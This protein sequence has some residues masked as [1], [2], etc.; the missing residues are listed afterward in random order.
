MNSLAKNTAFYFITSLAA[1]GMIFLLWIIL[2]W[3][4][5]P[6][7]IGVY[8]LA[9][10]VVELFGIV[11][12]FGL[13]PALARFYYADNN[14]ESN[15]VRVFANSFLIFLISSLLSLLLFIA[16]IN[17]ISF[18]IP[19]IAEV[20]KNNIVLLAGLI[21]ANSAVELILSNYTALKKAVVFSK[22]H[23]AR[24]ILFFVLSLAFISFEKSIVSIFLAFFVSS[25]AVI[26]YFFL[27][28]KKL[29]SFKTIDKN[30]I[31]QIASYGFPLMLYGFL[32][33][34]VLYFSRIILSWHVDLHSL[35]IYSF[36]LTIVL[37]IN[38]LWNTF[39]RAWTPEIFHSISKDKDKA[40]EQT[41]FMVFFSSF[42]YL[43]AIFF[44]MAAGELFLFKMIFKD[45]YFLNRMILYI[46]LIGPV[47]TGIYISIYPLC[48]YRKKSSKILAVSTFVSVLNILLVVL[49]VS[50]FSVLGA[51]LSYLAASALTALVYVLAFKK[52]AGIPSRVIFWTVFLSLFLSAGTLL[53]VATEAVWL[54]LPIIL[55][56]CVISFKAGRISEKK[57]LLL[58]IFKEL[59]LKIKNGAIKN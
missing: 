40:V 16:C 36:F 26:V 13:A 31:L 59:K 20:L 35:G 24:I 33:I 15:A 46:L 3:Y 42:I 52:D 54:F 8:S 6:S 38:G 53:F 11:S 34:V 14:G 5:N 22:F 7:Q 30:L 1:Q 10:F 47:F 23:L 17:L 58:D 44:I 32:G 9:M 55:L 56:G 57:T 45:I 2:A 18:L 48:Y 25:L 51:A 29:I 28:E 43:L 27:K 49:L 39:N 50:A 37:Q 41:A 19:D 12:L 4:L 21:V